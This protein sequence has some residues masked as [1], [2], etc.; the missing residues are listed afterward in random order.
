MAQISQRRCVTKHYPRRSSPLNRH[1]RTTGWRSVAPVHGSGAGASRSPSLRPP[2]VF[3]RGTE[4]AP[5]PSDDSGGD[6]LVGGVW[7]LGQVSELSRWRWVAGFAKAVDPDGRQAQ[8][9]GGDDVVEVGLGYVDQAGAGGSRAGQELLP[10]TVGGLVGADV[11]GRDRHVERHVD[12]VDRRG[13]QVGVAVRQRRE[14]P[15]APPHLG[16]G[17]RHLRE[18]RPV[19]ERAAEGVAV[20]LVEAGPLLGGDLLQ[21]LGHHLAVG[22]PGVARLNLRLELVVA[23][24]QRLA[25]ASEDALQLRADARVPVDQ[26]A[27]AVERGPAIHQRRPSAG[28]DQPDHVVRGPPVRFGKVASNGSAAALVPN[29]TPSRA[30]MN[31]ATRPPLSSA[32]T[33]ARPSI[34]EDSPPTRPVRRPS[35]APCG[36]S[37]TRATRISTSSPNSDRAA[38]TTTTSIRAPSNTSSFERTTPRLLSSCARASSMLAVPRRGTGPFGSGVPGLE[39][40]DEDRISWASSRL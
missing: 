6:Q 8:L 25:I 40:K 30:F 29:P 20:G 37:S 11:A 1:D 24:Q 17:L 15:A 28:L 33:S 9:G 38:S 31:C 36:T 26:R 13:E 23:D 27:V 14:P 16:E 4:L 32:T 34:T 7:E 39:R 12:A 2:E 35:R 19:R 5:P 18:D 10:V 22:Q 21:H 3:T